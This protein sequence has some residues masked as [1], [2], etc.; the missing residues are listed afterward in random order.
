MENGNPET[1]SIKDIQSLLVEHQKPKPGVCFTW[2]GA[3][4]KTFDGQVYRLVSGHVEN[5]VNLI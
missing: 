3:H 1:I 4:F 2:G 5:F